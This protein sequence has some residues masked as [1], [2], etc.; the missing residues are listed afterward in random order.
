MREIERENL[1]LKFVELTFSVHLKK[2]VY[3]PLLL[4]CA[5]KEVDN[6]YSAVNISTTEVPTEVIGTEA[7]FG[8]LQHF[9]IAERYFFFK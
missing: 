5:L 2:R 9:S 6:F 3:I 1:N 7:C 4:H 8:W